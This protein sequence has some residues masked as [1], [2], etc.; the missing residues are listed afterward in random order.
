VKILI[1]SPVSLT[2]STRGTTER[3]L[4]LALGLN[5]FNNKVLIFH[6]GKGKIPNLQST[7]Y[8]S[9]ERLLPAFK[10]GRL[11][12]RLLAP[13][14][15]FLIVKLISWIK[16]FKPEI[17]Q[18]EFPILPPF[19]QK[20]LKKMLKRKPLIVLDAHNVD[21]LAFK[22]VSHPFLYL[23]TYWI[24]RFNVK[25]CDLLLTV[26]YE[27]AINFT[28]IYGVAKKKIFLVPNGVNL[29]KC[30]GLNQQ[31]ARRILRLNED[32]KIVFFHGGY[33]LPNLEA[34]LTIIKNIAP[35]VKKKVKDVKFLIAG[36][37]CQYLKLDKGM[38]DGI[39]LLGYV[40]NVKLFI[41][42]A[43][44]CLVP[45]FKGGGTSLKILE[46]LACKKPV[47]TTSKGARGFNPADFP[48]LIIRENLEEITNFIITSF[49]EEEKR[50]FKIDYGKVERIIQRYDWMVISKKLNDLYCNLALS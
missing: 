36:E 46:Y 26:S 6:A 4:R 37:I 12:D 21:Y 23:Y 7:S 35:K 20:L 30:K 48:N 29:K 11:L 33:N 19:F 34:A 14:N 15:P 3:I 47:I 44:M 2:P 31:R 49:S 24:E 42:A 43:D 5:K 16:R 25:D 17:L 22:E 27:D 10:Y 38:E 40:P 41:S 8:F 13:F 32:D 9:F 1:V 28:K 18:F 39:K 45:T 50:Y